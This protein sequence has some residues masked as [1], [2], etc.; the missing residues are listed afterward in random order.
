[1]DLDR[2]HTTAHCISLVPRQQ[3]RAIVLLQFFCVRLVAVLKEWKCDGFAILVTLS[4]QFFLL[5]RCESPVRS[6]SSRTKSVFTSASRS[7][8]CDRRPAFVRYKIMQR[9]PTAIPTST[10]I[11]PTTPVVVLILAA[12][13]SPAVG[14]VCKSLSWCII[15][16]GYT[17][18]STMVAVSVGSQENATGVKPYG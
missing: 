12:V 4:C 3:P 5:N 10:A 17:D 18:S 14:F 11:G 1:M 15:Y 8:V 7:F 16:T 6:R 9:M 13:E 2:D